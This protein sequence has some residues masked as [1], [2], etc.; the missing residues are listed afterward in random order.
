MSLVLCVQLIPFCAIISNE[1]AFFGLKPVLIPT[2]MTDK[3]P[4]KQLQPD[5]LRRLHVIEKVD[6]SISSN[7]TWKGLSDNPAQ[8]I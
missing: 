1:K 2:G 3:F 6:C 4:A 5:S 8:L 7:W